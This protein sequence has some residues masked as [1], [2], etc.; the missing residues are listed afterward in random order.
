MGETRGEK[1]ERKER[2]RRKMRVTGK[3]CIL[4]SRIVQERA[5]RLKKGRDG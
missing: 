3:S 4:L 2:A 5:A 1:R